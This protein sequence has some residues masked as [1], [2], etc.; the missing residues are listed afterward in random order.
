M[1]IIEDK[2]Q[3]LKNKIKEYKS[4]IVAYS[5]GV[6]STFLLAVAH[7]V[8]GDNCLAVI[9]TSSLYPKREYV[10]ATKWLKKNNI[11][12]I[13]IES[14]E[15][16]I[17]GFTNNPTDRCYFCKKELFS[18]IYEI[19]KHREIDV[20]FDGTNADDANDHRPGMKAAEEL[21]VVRPLLEFGFTKN[22]IRKL[23]EEIYRLPTAKKQPMACMA[24]RIP[25]GEK[26]TKKKLS[27]IEEIEDYL[28]SKG[29]SIFRARHHGEILRLEL[30][31]EEL[32][33]IQNTEL[34]K[35]IVNFCKRCG[36]TYITLD[37]EGFRSGSMNEVLE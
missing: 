13:E 20:V 35:D 1:T 7:E 33:K 4:C 6:D 31:K 28:D 29:F 32:N 34:A 5:G 8:L 11:K 23:S 21:N 12:Y 27:Q 15:L 9:A 30:G 26:I 3:R 10:F 2:L 22:D 36:F 25:Y 37:L 14:E 18:K 24:S 19:A 16:N 17:S